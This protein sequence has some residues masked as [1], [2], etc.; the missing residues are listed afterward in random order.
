[1]YSGWLL[2]YSSLLGPITGIMIVDYFIVRQQNYELAELYKTQDAY[3]SFNRHG[4][5][6]FFVPIAL[7]LF[8]LLTG[9]L[10]WFCQYGWFYR[11][12]PR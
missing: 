4:L 7:A 5:T 10:S 9:E 1:M 6:A 12:F 11:L 8:T 2:G 3:G